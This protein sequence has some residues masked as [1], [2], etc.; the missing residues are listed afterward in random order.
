MHADLV[1]AWVQRLDARPSDALLLAARA[2]HIRR[3]EI[4]RRTYP[5]GRAGYLRWRDALHAHHGSLTAGVLSAEGFD[6][7]TVTRVCELVEKR[8]PVDDP[9]AQTLEDALCLVFLETQLAALADR[10]DEDKVVRVLRRTTRKMSEAAR[11]EITDL[12]FTPDAR[13]LVEQALC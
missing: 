11:R 13:A 6:Q 10:L 3:W 5:S 1:T 9:E 2:H 4:P 12:A 8:S 7:G